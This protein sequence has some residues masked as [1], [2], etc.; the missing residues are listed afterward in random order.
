MTDYDTDSDQT[1]DQDP[2]AY[3]C[4]YDAKHPLTRFILGISALSIAGYLLTKLLT[5]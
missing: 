5:T 4:M 3:L 1:Q 2:W